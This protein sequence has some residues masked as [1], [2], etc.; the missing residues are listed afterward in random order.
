M[1]KYGKKP[2]KSVRSD[3]KVAKVGLRSK[4]YGKQSSVAKKSGKES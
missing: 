2:E 3:T 1:N 4:G